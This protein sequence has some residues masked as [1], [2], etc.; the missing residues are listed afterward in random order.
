MA[1]SRVRHV[2]VLSTIRVGQ[3]TGTNGAAWP[4]LVDPQGWPL[5]NDTGPYGVL[6]VD[7]GANIVHG[8]K[9]YIFFGDVA[10]RQG[11]GDIE[12]SSLILTRF[13][14]GDVVLTRH[15]PPKRGGAEDI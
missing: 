5:V 9:T 15:L 1:P 10:T 3:L 11:P 12:N 2:E 4:D 14:A 13:L 8:D 6:G 7:L